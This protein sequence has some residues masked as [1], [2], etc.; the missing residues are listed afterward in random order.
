MDGLE[1]FF[2][3]RITDISNDL[4]RFVDNLQPSNLTP[5]LQQK[6]LQLYEY[7]LQ[8]GHIHPL[9]NWHAHRIRCMSCI[10]TK[11]QDPLRIWQCHGHILEYSLK[12]CSCAC[13]C[14]DVM[15][16]ARGKNHDYFHR[17]SLNYVVYGS[18]ALVNACLYLQPTTKFDYMFIFHPVLDLLRPYLDGKKKH[19]EFVR[20][21]IDGDKTR[22]E[23]QQH[24]DPD[25]AKTFLRLI[26][27]LSSFS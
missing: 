18:Q 5:S 24:W 6:L 3:E 19:V 13:H 10:A 20:S 4:C 22:K 14:S 2:V 25:Y 27:Q 16:K 12:N 9:T 23:Y 8:N 1:S 17:D 21:E 15:M 26:D 11:L 7:H